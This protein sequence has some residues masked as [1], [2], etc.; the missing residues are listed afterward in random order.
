MRSPP[1]WIEY[2]PALQ[3]EHA[4]EPAAMTMMLNPKKLLAWSATRVRWM[5]EVFVKKPARRALCVG[6]L[7]FKPGNH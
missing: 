3:D 6:T 2:F 1:V 4:E 7:Q 5:N